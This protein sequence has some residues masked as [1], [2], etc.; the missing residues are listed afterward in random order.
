[1]LSK[2]KLIP[3]AS[4]IAAATIST[5][6]NSATWSD[7]FIGITQGAKFKEPG[8]PADVEKTIATLQYVGGYKYGVNFFSVDMLQSDHA[9]PAIGGTTSS[10]R[11]AQ[12]VYAVYNNTVSFGKLGMNT[13]FGPIRD[14]GFQ[15]GFDFNSKNDAFGAG[16]VK[17]IAGP[18]LEFDVNGL[19]T[20]GLL[21]YKENNNNGISGKDVNFD[22]TARLATVWSFDYDWVVPTTFKGWATYTQEK[23]KDGFGGNTA[24]ETWLESALL[25]DLAQVTGQPKTFYAGVGYQYIKNKFGNQP[26][27]PGTKVSAPSVKMEVHF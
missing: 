12:E 27:V 1:M 3:L 22:G 10:G 18:K 2:S 13:K 11:A 7:S 21:Y 19:L 16:L 6:A 23:G 24:P 25:V 8:S 5:G 9:N 4:A 14:V 26:S 20:L 17:W 15:A